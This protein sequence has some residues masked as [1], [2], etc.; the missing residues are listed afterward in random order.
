MVTIP[1]AIIRHNG[2]LVDKSTKIVLYF[3]ELTADEDYK[4][5]SYAKNQEVG[6]IL[7]D[8]DHM[9]A[10]MEVISQAT[11]ITERPGLIEAPV[12][13]E[14]GFEIINHTENEQLI[15]ESSGEHDG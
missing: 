4:I 9:T 2:L 15:S 6:V 12:L 10:I 8:P 5:F 13:D 7:C 11:Q 3:P 1:N 14:D